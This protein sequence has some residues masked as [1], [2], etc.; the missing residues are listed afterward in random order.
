MTEHHATDVTARGHERERKPWRAPPGGPVTTTTMTTPARASDATGPIGVDELKRAW[1]AVRAGD[2]RATS[3]DHRVG[4]AAADRWNPERG[5]LTLP[6]LGCAG[7]V[8]ATTLALAVGSAAVR[9]VRVVECGSVTTSGLAAASTAELGRHPAGWIQGR[10][11]QVLLERAAKNC[12][13]PTAIPHP[14]PAD[15]LTREEEEAPRGTLTILDAGWEATQLLASGS[16]LAE[17][18]TDAP[19]LVLVTRAT[20]PGIRRLDG[21]LT[22]L[23]SGGR[24]DG[25]NVAVLGP[26]RK[27]WPRGLVAAGGPLARRLLEP[28]RVVEIPEIAALA[29]AGLD[30]RPLPTPVIDA[31]QRLVPPAHRRQPT[32]RRGKGDRHP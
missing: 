23:A 28:E 20:V 6:V 2:F 30:S 31:A 18:I 12:L 13:D 8:G 26:R 16:W 5:E 11:D 15:P 10:R 1:Q 4:A 3:R 21:V 19:E 22:L 17:V 29:A 24:V 14:A 9:P 27:K 25:I 32:H 7:S